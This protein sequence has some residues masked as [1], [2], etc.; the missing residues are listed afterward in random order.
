MVSGWLS[1]L[2]VY[3]S[4]WCEEVLPGLLEFD[5][6]AAVWR[7]VV[8][9]LYLFIYDLSDERRN[10][11]ILLVFLCT[12][13]TLQFLLSVK[14]LDVYSRW[15]GLLVVA[16]RLT[17]CFGCGNTMH[18]VTTGTKDAYSFFKNLTMASGVVVAAQANFIH[19]EMF[20]LSC[21]FGLIQVLVLWTH[22][23]EVCREGLLATDYGV[24][25]TRKAF[26]FVKDI[27]YGAS[28]GLW[29]GNNV[30]KPE[31]EATDPALV[32]SHDLRS[33]VCLLQ[34]LQMLFGFFFPSIIIYLYEQQ[35]METW[36]MRSHRSLLHQGMPRGA[37]WANTLRMYGTIFY[38]TA[39]YLLLAGVWT[40]AGMCMIHGV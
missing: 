31:V 12:V 34:T 20:Q 4:F 28:G 15:R 19:R 39:R 18:F 37:S 5:A 17:T 3:R 32:A 7:V 38:D 21:V 14:R 27:I 2:R 24:D 8:I 23:E 29:L 6:A 11:A 22:S 40:W 30:R 10:P 9:I 36:R 35:A 16:L 13:C 25:L 1:G 26:G 33:C